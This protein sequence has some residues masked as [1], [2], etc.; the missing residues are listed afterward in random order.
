MSVAPVSG[1]RVGAGE[2]DTLA[3]I[4]R[5]FAENPVAGHLGARAIACDPLAGRITVE[6]DARPEFTNLLGSVQGGL[7]GA[8][9]DIV[10]SFAALC[11]MGGPG[12]VV[13]T[14]EMKTNFI[15]P[16]RPGRIVG[17]GWL[18]RKGRSIAF[19][20]GRLLDGHGTLLTTGT[21]TGRLG[22]WPPRRG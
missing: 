13:P 5:S 16:A 20:E 18:V 6:F 22:R 8:M 14:L 15:T 7:L 2:S 4:T 12:W 11:T 19:M 17:E 10:M 9:L 1:G 3:W 21:A